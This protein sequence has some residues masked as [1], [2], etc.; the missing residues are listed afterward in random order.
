MD[1]LANF[2]SSFV[3]QLQ[4]PTL[5]FLIGG[6]V[7]AATGSKLAIPDAVYRF[8]IFVLLMSIGLHGGMEIREAD[9]TE[10]ALP[11][12][13][14]A[15]IGVIAVLLGA[16]TLGRLPGVSKDDAYAT[17]GLFGAV[18]ASTL[19]VAMVVLE[20]KEIPF[21]AWAPALYPFMDIPALILA[22]V[23]ASLAK[24]KQSGEKAKRVAIGEII[25]DSLRSSALSALLLGLAIGFIAEPREVHEGF[26]DLLFRGFLSVL[27]L[28]MGME[29]WA[30]LS[31]LRRVAH[32]YAA[33]AVIAPITHGLIGFGLG[34]IAHVL[35]GFSPGGVI[36]LAIIAA[37]NSDISGPP[38][39]RAGI[40]GANPSSFIGA[41]TSVGTPIAI[42]VCVPLFVALAEVVFGL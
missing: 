27:M 17:A 10:L 11:A 26:Y 41:S 40:P 39:L 5:A 3:S 35:V 6:M 16:Q 19:A 36:I 38:T 2:A 33:Y 34:Y 8:I 23:L 42:A 30:R 37:S 13:F 21:E 28:V 31:E 22:I 29:A 24:A 9:P 20:E 4:S 14:A 12:L 15:L 25:K 1:L 32:W 7:L 18:S